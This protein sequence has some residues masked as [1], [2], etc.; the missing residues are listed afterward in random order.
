MIQIV[1]VAVVTALAALFLR[2]VKPD[3]SFAVLVCGGIVLLLFAVDFLAD[4]IDVLWDIVN[5]TGLD[6]NLVKLILKI[7]GVGYL[8]EFTA[9]IV[10]DF[11]ASALSDKVVLC[12]KLFIL[13]LAVP[14]LQALLAFVQAFLQLV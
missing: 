8:T 13:L 14:I 4:T 10:A 3:L 1:A 9:Q 7:I 6:H 12:G 5:V 2:S 11:G